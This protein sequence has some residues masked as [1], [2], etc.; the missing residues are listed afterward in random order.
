MKTGDNSLLLHNKQP[1]GLIEF[2]EL[3]Y[4]LLEQWTTDVAEAMWD[5]DGWFSADSPAL[6]SSGEALVT[7]EAGKRGT[8]GDGKLLYTGTS[9]SSDIDV[10]FPNANAV[11]YQVGLTEA[12]YP[13]P[14]GLKTHDET[15]V[16]NWNYERTAVGR[17]DE[18]SLITDLGAGAMRV[19]LS[20][21]LEDANDHAGRTVLLW[22]KA[23]A[24]SVPTLAI[25]VLGDGRKILRQ[26]ERIG[27]PVVFPADALV[28]DVLAES[29]DYCL[30]PDGRTR[31]VQC[32][33]QARSTVE[34]IRERF[35]RSLETGR[36][37]T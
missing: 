31:A 29:L 5:E 15:G 24:T 36:R 37:S 16:P 13:I 4:D 20:T 10:P 34:A 3:L 12:K 21:L 27:W 17:L 1:L 22:M 14:A 25:D 11:V 9:D 19:S 32:A 28:D 30:S 2:R 23:P 6:T 26:C 35:I 8:D 18:P 7:V 33:A